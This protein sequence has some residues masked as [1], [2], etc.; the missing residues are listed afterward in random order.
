MH[1]CSKRKTNN[2]Q[3]HSNKRQGSCWCIPSDPG[4][5]KRLD[6]FQRLD[7]FAVRRREN[8]VVRIRTWYLRGANN[9]FKVSVLWGAWTESWVHFVFSPMAPAAAAISSTHLQQR[10]GSLNPKKSRLPS[11]EGENKTWAMKKGKCERRVV[12]FLSRRFLTPTTLHFLLKNS[13]YR[14]TI[15]DKL[16]KKKLSSTSF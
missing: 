14:T 16:K 10:A 6:L 12:P 15:F 5:S 11:L 1:T 7:L 3:T 9:P 4:A 8:G 2:R 13:G